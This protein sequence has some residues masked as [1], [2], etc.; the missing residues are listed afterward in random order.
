MATQWSIARPSAASSSLSSSSRIVQA[1]PCSSRPRNS[2]MAER[3]HRISVRSASTR[4]RAFHSSTRR[5]SEAT[6]QPF[7]ERSGCGASRSTSVSSPTMTRRGSNL[8]SCRNST[9]GSTWAGSSLGWLMKKWIAE[10]QNS[11]SSC[12]TPGP[13]GWRRRHGRARRSRPG[14]GPAPSG[15]RSRSGSGPGRG[16]TRG[17][18]AGSAGSGTR[19]S[20]RLRP[21]PARLN[22]RCGRRPSQPSPRNQAESK[23]GGTG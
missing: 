9:T 7:S 4:R 6:V 13:G 8:W 10:T 16:R 12:R 20:R 14:P 5:S 22:Q 21:R 1:R 2:P 11:S 3:S 15:G 18:S 19:L 23:T 17:P